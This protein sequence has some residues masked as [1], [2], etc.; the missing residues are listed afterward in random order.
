MKQTASITHC[1]LLTQNPIPRLASPRS[2]EL[3]A[4]K[5]TNKQRGVNKQGGSALWECLHWIR[6]PCILVEM[7]AWSA[8]VSFLHNT[9]KNYGQNFLFP[10]VFLATRFHFNIPHPFWSSFA[11]FTSVARVSGWIKLAGRARFSQVSVFRVKPRN[12]LRCICNLT[13]FD[14]TLIGRARFGR[15]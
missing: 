7:A 6:A 15:V 14:V 10:L 4:N 1:L 5:Q 2:R 9:L 11:C 13:A 12:P 3:K 8:C